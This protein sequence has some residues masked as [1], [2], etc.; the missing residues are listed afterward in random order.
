M[1]NIH[2]REDIKVITVDETLD[3]CVRCVIGQQIERKI[4]SNHRSD[5]F[6]RMDGSVNHDC[7][8]AAFA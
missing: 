2:D 7:R 1:I 8:L 5:P 6:S 4:L 3:L